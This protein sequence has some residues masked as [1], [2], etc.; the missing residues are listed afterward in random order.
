MFLSNK[1]TSCIYSVQDQ[2]LP[3]PIP[4][5]GWIVSGVGGVKSGAGGLACPAG[6]PIDKRKD[7]AGGF[8][9]S[10]LVNGIILGK[11]HNDR[12]LFSALVHHG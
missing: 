7:A 10:H 9:T 2:P 3:P 8:H 11:C 5:Q 4:D 12:S 6:H 1:S